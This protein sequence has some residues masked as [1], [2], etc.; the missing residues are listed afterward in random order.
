MLTDLISDV[1]DLLLSHRIVRRV[2]FVA[3]VTASLYLWGP[4]WPLLGIW[5]LIFGWSELQDLIWRR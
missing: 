4:V 2:L 5:I 3:L 1:W